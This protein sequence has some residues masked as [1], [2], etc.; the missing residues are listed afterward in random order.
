MTLTN[1]YVLSGTSFNMNFLLLAVQVSRESLSTHFPFPGGG[2]G[3][4]LI[5]LGNRIL[6]VSSRFS[7]VNPWAS[8][9]TA[10]SNGTK[11]EN[12]SPSRSS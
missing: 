2:G 5:G 1:K 11:A 6:S 9:T 4:V 10:T 3:L 12:G 7:F 8:S